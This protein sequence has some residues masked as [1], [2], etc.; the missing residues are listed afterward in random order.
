M[1]YEGASKSLRDEPSFHVFTCFDC[2]EL[3][4]IGCNTGPSAANPH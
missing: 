4:W 2:D 1:T 3:V